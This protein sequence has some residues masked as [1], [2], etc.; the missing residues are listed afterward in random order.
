MIQ[1]AT[2]F[3]LQN[4][5]RDSGAASQKKIEAVRNACQQVAN[6]TGE[7]FRKLLA[8]ELLSRVLHSCDELTKNDARELWRREFGEY[9]VET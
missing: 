6:G 4:L 5:L 9:P 7:D 3:A 1:S 2:L 8:D